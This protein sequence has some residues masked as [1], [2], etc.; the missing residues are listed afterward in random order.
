[1]SI[2]DYAK[3]STLFLKRLINILFILLSY[4]NNMVAIFVV[5][6]LSPEINSISFIF[7]AGSALLSF[8]SI[9]TLLTFLQENLFLYQHVYDLFSFMSFVMKEC[10]NFLLF[11]NWTSCFHHLLGLKILP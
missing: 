2:T 6:S 4:S 3:I 5:H 7:S 8:S 1:M 10:R 11:A 9:L